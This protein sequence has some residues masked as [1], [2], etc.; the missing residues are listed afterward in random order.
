MEPSQSSKPS[1]RSN[2]KRW[3][4][5]I[6]ASLAILIAVIVVI[7]ALR[8]IMLGTVFS[9]GSESIIGEP[10][11]GDTGAQVQLTPYLPA[12][13]PLL[14]AIALIFGLLTNRLLVAWI[15]LAVLALF[16][17]LFLFSEGGGFIIYDLL[18]LLLL[19]VIQLAR[20]T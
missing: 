19:G 11:L 4:E 2:L 3:L 20:R 18:L 10:S 14:A 7:H 6:A 15:S 17:L 9:P 8:L 13:I 12:V 5:R 1:V 16:S